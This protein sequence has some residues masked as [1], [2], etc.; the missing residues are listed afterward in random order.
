MEVEARNVPSSSIDLVH[1]DV[2]YG[3]VSMV[4]EVARIAARVLVPGGVLAILAGA[5]EPLA[6]L[7]SAADEGLTPLAIGSLV[8]QGVNFAR[9]GR[10]DRVERVDALPVYLFTHGKRLAQTISHL[11][12]VSE[13]KERF[14]TGGRRTW[15]P[16]STSCSRL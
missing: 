11:A 14:I 7:N 9:P 2:E 5:Y 1:A 13:R 6:I 12:F 8:L 15:P 16:R 10:T 4:S 3:D